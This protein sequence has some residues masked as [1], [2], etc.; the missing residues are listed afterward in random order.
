MSWGAVDFSGKNLILIEETKIEN[1]GFL[2]TNMFNF[3][4]NSL[5]LLSG[6][7]VAR[8]GWSFTISP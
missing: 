3:T 5:L 7:Y 2:T 6:V 8:T 1:E 4:I